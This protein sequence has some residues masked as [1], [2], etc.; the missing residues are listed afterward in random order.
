[1][2]LDAPRELKARHILGRESIMRRAIVAATVLVLS[3]GLAQ[4]GTL[5]DL[6]GDAVVDFAT[7]MDM[8]FMRVGNPGNTADTRYETPGYGGVDYTYNIG[9]YEITAGQYC[10]FLNAVAEIGRAHV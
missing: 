10:E 8:P 3:V 5:A 7:T 6:S 9:K 1:M 2:G 4:A